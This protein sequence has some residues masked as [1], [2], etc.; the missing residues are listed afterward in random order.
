MEAKLPAPDIAGQGNI[1]IRLLKEDAIP[2]QLAGYLEEDE[3]EADAEEDEDEAQRSY[4]FDNSLSLR[5]GERV[6]YISG[7]LRPGRYDLRISNFSTVPVAS[8]SLHVAAVLKNGPRAVWSQTIAKLMAQSNSTFKFEVQ[9]HLD[10]RC[11][12]EI[13][14]ASN[15]KWETSEE[16][17]QNSTRLVLS[18]CRQGEHH[19]IPSSVT[20]QSYLF[21]GQRVFGPAAAAN[22]KVSPQYVQGLTPEQEFMLSLREKSM[23]VANAPALSETEQPL[24]ATAAMESSLT[25]IKGG[26]STIPESNQ[27]QP[28]QEQI[29]PNAQQAAGITSF[30]KNLLG[31]TSLASLEEDTK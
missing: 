31:G 23:F 12:L 3:D 11:V 6:N 5:K 1:F 26:K 21:G 10:R 13:S 19:G 15:R 27:S 22:F 16:K 29:Q 8:S 25:W 9:P 28:R 24:Q 4:Y 30:I 2:N 18:L 20:G 17:Q 14:I 7:R